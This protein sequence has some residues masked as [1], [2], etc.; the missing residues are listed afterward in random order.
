M[1]SCAI[2]EDDVISMKMI[3]GMAEKTG[4]LH[5]NAS[6]TA[7]TEALKW[8]ATHQVDLLFLDIEMLELTGLELLRS[9][10]YKPDVIII[11]SQ[12]IRGCNSHQRVF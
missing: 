12:A 11:S 8:L 5:I 1:L 6:F 7:S 9:L 10:V 3:E 4:L 2:V